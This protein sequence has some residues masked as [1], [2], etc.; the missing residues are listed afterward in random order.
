[1][2]VRPTLYKLTLTLHQMSDL[3]INVPVHIFDQ[4]RTAQID[5]G[6][7]L[8]VISEDLVPFPNYIRVEPNIAINLQQYDGRPVKDHGFGYI[9]FKIGNKAYLYPMLIAANNTSKVLL[10]NDFLEN[11][12][13]VIDPT[14]RCLVSPVFGRV[15]FSNPPTQI[16]KRL[17]LQPIPIPLVNQL[18]ATHSSANQVMPH[19]PRPSRP[20]APRH[21]L[22][23]PPP[24]QSVN[25]VQLQQQVNLLSHPQQVFQ[26]S[27][28]AQ[29]QFVSPHIS[30]MQRR[31]NTVRR[32]WPRQPTTLPPWH[33]QGPNLFYQP[34]VQQALSSTHE[35]RVN[36]IVHH[37]KLPRSIIIPPRS[38]VQVRV[39]LQGEMM[40]E[41]FKRIYENHRL[42]IPR[43][44]LKNGSPLPIT[45]PTNEEKRIHRNTKLGTLT[46]LSITV[47]V[48]MMKA[49]NSNEAPAQKTTP[50]EVKTPVPDFNKIKISEDL[51][52]E[53]KMQVKD[54]IIRYA[55]VFSWAGEL[56][57][58][59][60]I[61]FEINTGNA[62][63]VRQRAYRTS[64][65]Q[66]AI[67]KDHIDSWLKAGIIEPSKASWSSPV[68]I[69]KKP[70]IEANK[71]EH[72]ICIDLRGVNAVTKP[73]VY[74]LPTIGTILSRLRNKKF[75]SQL[76]AASGFYQLGIKEEDKE[77]TTFVTEHGAFQ[78]NRMPMG[79]KNSSAYYQHFMDILLSDVKGK[80]A[81]AYVDDCLVSSKDFES[82]L[83]HLEDVLQRF[84]KAGVK[85]KPS[86]CKLGYEKLSVFG[87][88][89][90]AKGI[91]PTGKNVE[92][93]LKLPAPKNVK[94]LQSLLASFNYFRRFIKN[95][96]AK[97][98]PLRQLLRKE[99]AFQW[100]PQCETAYKD[101]K[102]ALTTAPVLTHFDPSLPTIIAV[103]ASLIGLGATLCQVHPDGEHPVCYISRSL[104]EA[105]AKW[106]VT[107]LEMLAM[108]WACK[109]LKEFIIGVPFLI[110]TDHCALCSI[111]RS[112]KTEMSPKMTRMVLSMQEFQITGIQHIKGAVNHT[113]DLLSRLGH[114]LEREPVKLNLLQDSTLHMDQ[115]SDEWI[116]KTKEDIRS[117]RATPRQLKKFMIATSCFATTHTP[118]EERENSS[119][120]CQSNTKVIC[121]SLSMTIRVD[122][123]LA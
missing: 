20:M 85:L 53:E 48:N 77:K 13:A 119:I 122:P 65:S 98:E 14:E 74:P 41:P 2:S 39:E 118:L 7:T 37:L 36:T 99:A 106:N 91:Q 9:P 111:L 43:C 34:N 46:T 44:L 49:I 84:R 23:P 93:V 113:P 73:Y 117:G 94:E 15:S 16:F 121:S 104:T 3:D 17:G 38:E 58:S 80:Y 103:D 89:V 75:F 68:V 18:R 27:Q 22:G 67:L 100:T 96:S 56:G 51:S 120:V 105:E 24:P 69:V 63:P 108:T 50:E 59:N 109:K 123:T 66:N 70:T 83:L 6:A 102:K 64:D 42:L 12:S 10:G 62:E 60:L 87:H 32:P 82:H 78:F 71:E 21:H 95:F 4:L 45:N 19:P 29:S 26:P 54:L 28:V 11:F 5:T 86:K 8:S 114:T 90:S 107:E 110:K 79:A 81:Q 72:R 33:Y 40:F 88:D 25:V 52:L 55:D 35:R 116:L 97:A 31:V 61:E 30:D 92:A 115:D 76:D 57:F 47:Q 112:R 1:M 101:L